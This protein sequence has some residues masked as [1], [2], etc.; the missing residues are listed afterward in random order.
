MLGWSLEANEAEIKQTSGLEDKDSLLVW[1]LPGIS[2]PHLQLAFMK[3]E[4]I[5]SDLKFALITL[6]IHLDICVHG[7]LTLLGWEYA[8]TASLASG[9]QPI[10]PDYLNGQFTDMSGSRN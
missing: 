9:D 7:A 10:H 8:M 1:L 2:W 5:V 4:Q 6:F 3:F